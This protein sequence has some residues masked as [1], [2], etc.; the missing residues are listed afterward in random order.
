MQ[1]YSQPPRQSL[2]PTVIPDD[3]PVY[4]ILDGKFYADDEL[5][6]AGSIL[7]WPDEPNEEMMPLNTLAR[8]K[9]VEYLQKLDRLGRQAAEKAGKS[10]VSKEDA[11]RNAMEAARDEGRRVTLLNGKTDTPIMGARKKGPRKA[12]QITLGAEE[13][14]PVIPGANKKA[15]VEFI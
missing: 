3:V 6:E 11:F 4:K 13:T 1:L 2:A 10:Y 12:K 14:V 5:F 7:V 8:Q 9:H 15:A